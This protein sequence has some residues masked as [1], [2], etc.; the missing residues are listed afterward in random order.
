MT[1]EIGSA[2]FQLI[3]KLGSG[4]MGVVF[5]A[6]DRQNDA[7]VAIKT[8]KHC[9][10]EALYRFKQ[11]FRALADIHHP[12]LLRFGELYCEHEQWF[13]TM[14]LVRGKSFIDYIRAPE[15][16]E[17]GD[18]DDVPTMQVAT[19]SPSIHLPP[20]IRLPSLGARCDEKRLRSASLQLAF[21]ISA[22]HRSGRVHRDVKPSNVLVR[23]DGRLVLL[24]FGLIG[25]IGDRASSSVVLGTPAYMAPEQV[26][27]ASV[28]PAADWYA[29]GVMLFV[30]LTGVLPFEGSPESIMKAKCNCPSP[31]PIDL[32]PEVPLDL[33]D[34]CCAL[35]AIEPSA[36]PEGE[37]IVRRLGGTRPGEASAT[38]LGAAADAGD[39]FVGRTAELAE[40]GKSFGRCMA[41]RSELV[42]IRGE[43]GVGKSTLVHA[44]L[45][46][47]VRLDPTSLV[48]AGRCYEQESVPFKAFDTVIDSL[49]SHLCA[50][51]EMA[52]AELLHSGVRYLA[53]VFPVLKRVPAIARRVPSERAVASS[54]TLREQAFAELK[55]LLAAMARRVPLVLFIDDLQWADNDSLALLAALFV[56]PDAPRCLFVGTLRARGAAQTASSI[57]PR[58]AALPFRFIELRGL[59]RDE[60]RSLWNRLWSAAGPSETADNLAGWLDEAIGHPLFLSELV[61]YARTAQDRPLRSRLQDVLWQRISDLD[62]PARR[63]MELVALAGAPIKYQ[64]VAEAAGID[65]ATSANLLGALRSAQLIRLNRAADERLVEPYHDRMREAIVQHLE[66]DGGATVAQ[67]RLGLG[68]RMLEHTSDEELA[69]AVFR[70]VGHLNAATALIQT[71][72]ERRR[73]AELNLLAGRQARLSTAYGAGIGYLACGIALID[74][75]SWASDYELCRQLHWERMETEYLAGERELGL[76][77]FRELLPSLR[78]DRERADLYVSKIGLD[79]GQGRH[80]EAIATA[81]EALAYWDEPI[82]RQPNTASI[83]REYAAMRIRQGR[84][85][86]DELIELPD[87]HDVKKLCALK[88]LV[89]MSPA[90]FF[91]SLELLTIVTIRLAQLSLRYG[92]S[93]ESA[94]AFAGY[95]LV[96]AGAFGKYEEAYAFGQLAQRILE[97]LHS[98]AFTCKVYFLNGTYLTSWVRP[99]AEAKQQL[100]LARDAGLKN[101]DMAYEAYSAATLS[102][103]TYCEAEHLAK[104]QACAESSYEITSR[105]RDEDMSAMMIA[106]ARYC[107]ALRGLGPERDRLSSEDSTD[108]EFRRSLDSAR[109]PVALFYY[110]FL[111]AQ[112]AYL[113][114]DLGRACVMLQKA[115]PHTRVIH[116]IPTA[117]ELELWRALVVARTAPAGS[118]MERLTLARMMQRS[119][120]ELARCARVCPQNFAAHYRLAIAER[121]RAL[122]KR[123]TGVRFAEAI[124]TARQRGSRKWEPLALELAA[125]YQWTKGDLERAHE[126]T[127]KAIDAYRRWGAEA[128]A[129]ALAQRA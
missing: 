64:V 29:F 45:E 23:N 106:H 26:L 24:D 78:R 114:G 69:A 111:N 51:E 91:T 28:G 49:S 87:L 82:P 88:I 116:S 39:V 129:E 62:E 75:E 128:K 59:S 117:L 109:T 19:D 96:L 5:E 102:V 100:R 48:L 122:R 50:L 63:F 10:G 81:R 56:P 35:L 27:K 3:S 60:A 25:D 126:Y 85:P 83:L 12:N 30:A 127:R 71:R 89:A 20:A 79:T 66:G 16:S 17:P 31:A 42:L 76:R 77:H 110:Y 33:N 118:T 6:Y 115:D 65:S 121:A 123:D 21:A 108:E 86:I 37:E 113:Y 1:D 57:E 125:E 70:I 67:L 13:F 32:Q 99:F 72:A 43:T 95:G 53:S 46:R 93:H 15:A 105:R 9:D 92:V 40:L 107:A 52:L 55:Q 80:L 103:I 18:E 8:L 38:P 84:R 104:M 7:L 120:G 73:V 2:R 22:L 112:L 61:R 74:E 54:V 90:A 124:E 44:F 68:R 94:F 11:E 41:G 58:L 101:G 36:R 119:L 47:Q 98:H 4:G 14:E 97:R 34:L